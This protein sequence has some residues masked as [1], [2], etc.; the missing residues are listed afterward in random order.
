M[1]LGQEHKRLQHSS[2]SLR[3]G[4]LLKKSEKFRGALQ[5][6]LT[7]MAGFRRKNLQRSWALLDQI[8]IGIC[9]IDF[10]QL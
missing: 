5:S 6:T 4:F 9:Q 2:C 3:L 7:R 1:T 8:T 10:S